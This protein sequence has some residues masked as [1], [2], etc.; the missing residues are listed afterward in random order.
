MKDSNQ[1]SKKSKSSFEQALKK[2][3][4]EKKEINPK[5]AKKSFI[6][7]KKIFFLAKYRILEDAFN[8]LKDHNKQYFILSS[9]F[10]KIKKDKKS[11]AMA[12]LYTHLVKKNRSLTNF[13]NIIFQVKK[14]HIRKI[15]ISLKYYFY[16][17]RIVF[18]KFM[19]I[20]KVLLKKS[21]DGINHFFENLKT[22]NKEYIGD[23]GIPE[24]IQEET[25]NKSE[26]ELSNSNNIFEQNSIVS[27]EMSNQLGVSQD[28]Q[29]KD[30]FLNKQ[31]N[32]N[33]FFNQDGMKN[34]QM[35][36]NGTFK[37]DSFSNSINKED[38]K[39]DNKQFIDKDQ[40]KPIKKTLFS[41]PNLRDPLLN[42]NQTPEV[43]P[44]NQGKKK[45][46]LYDENDESKESDSRNKSKPQIFRK[47][48]DNS[49]DNS[50]NTERTNEHSVSID[51]NLSRNSNLLNVNSNVNSQAN[52]RYTHEEIEDSVES[53]ENQ[54]SYSNQSQNENRS[55]IAKINSR[56]SD[57]DDTGNSYIENSN[58]DNFYNRQETKSAE[59]HY[60][61]DPKDPEKMQHFANQYSSL[62][63][64]WKPSMMKNIKQN[65]KPF[66]NKSSFLSTQARTEQLPIKK[67]SNKR[68]NKTLSPNLRPPSPYQSKKTQSSQYASS[69]VNSFMSKY[70]SKRKS[71]A[72]TTQSEISSSKL[73]SLLGRRKSRRS[74][75]TS[76]TMPRKKSTDY[77]DTNLS[78]HSKGGPNSFEVSGYSP[79]QVSQFSTHTNNIN[80][81]FKN[82]MTKVVKALLDHIKSKKRQNYPSKAYWDNED[83]I[84]F[85]RKFLEVINLFDVYLNTLKKSGNQSNQLLTLQENISKMSRPLKVLFENKNANLNQNIQYIKIETIESILIFI[86]QKL[87]LE[88]LYATDLPFNGSVFFFGSQA[89]SQLPYPGTLYPSQNSGSLF[90]LSQARMGFSNNH[91][92]NSNQRG[93]PNR[94]YLKNV[95]SHHP[96]GRQ[97]REFKKRFGK[98]KS[99]SNSNNM[100]FEERQERP[101]QEMNTQYIH[102]ES[103]VI[104][105]HLTNKI[106]TFRNPGYSLTN[107]CA[108]L[109]IKLR[110]KIR[111]VFEEALKKIKREGALKSWKPKF[112][113]SGMNKRILRMLFRLIRKNLDFKV[114]NA[115]KKL[116]MNRIKP[117]LSRGNSPYSQQASTFSPTYARPQNKVSPSWQG[118]NKIQSSEYYPTK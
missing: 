17:K 46:K 76:Q 13:Q 51:K 14:I 65:I 66:K 113:H 64:F 118:R 90:S 10:Y 42:A 4:E 115:L 116:R 110:F 18:D 50:V 96:S 63:R 60:A 45:S 55:P 87:E 57:N 8:V 5:Q 38:S 61:N 37:K 9:L 39:T 3:K 68:S 85:V 26:E 92:L 95:Q 91:N 1:V 97:E 103:L 104:N 53:D 79:S 93:S 67:K 56:F 74:K 24:V 12:L 54:F 6:Y 36:S 107:F 82:N 40:Y 99:F 11:R 109:N 20:H 34:N 47:T 23:S 49:L 111:K 73:F 105:N 62:N 48:D 31:S 117:V 59:K 108:L 106:K 71:R 80:N 100:I 94:A 35:T 98:Q 7:L 43:Y 70:M 32:F 114:Q 30:D 28:I 21:K 33:T 77:R 83:K 58:P 78:T 84:L 72:S 102:T 25:E 89:S 112:V 44:E 86:Y 52:N 75:Q 88:N 27:N 69:R 15:L 22:I 16:S 41:N 29:S 19:V 81:T 2:L 101:Y